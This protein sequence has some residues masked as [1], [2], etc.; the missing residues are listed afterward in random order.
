MSDDEDSPLKLAAYALAQNLALQSICAMLMAQIALLY[1]SPPDKLAEI[2][3]GL[4]GV[5][6][7]A[8]RHD[9][10]STDKASLTLTRTMENVCGMAE[11]ILVRRPNQPPNK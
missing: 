5:I 4:Q 1:K 11:A 10:D 7:G 8:V 9:G 2:T 3:S 6:H